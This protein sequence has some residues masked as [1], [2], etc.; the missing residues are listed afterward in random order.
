MSPELRPLKWG[1]VRFSIC[2]SFASFGVNGAPGIC[3]RRRGPPHSL[4]LRPTEG[5]GCRRAKRCRA[6]SRTGPES[7]STP[8]GTAGGDSILGFM[9]PPPPTFR[10][11]SVLYFDRRSREARP[12][13]V[14]L[15]AWRVR[16][17]TWPGLLR[18]RK[19]PDMGGKCLLQCSRQASTD[20]ILYNSSW[21]C[22][23]CELRIWGLGL[24]GERC[25]ES[26]QL[27]WTAFRGPAS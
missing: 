12:T 13:V 20:V 7:L 19:R 21:F 23:V 18:S 25:F 11:A 16:A 17:P 27:F 2:F 9:K 26:S 3:P 14:L 10:K 5:G 24:G 4:F 6:E 22:R 1:E 8:T 15:G